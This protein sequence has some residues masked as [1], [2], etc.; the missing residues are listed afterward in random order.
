ML[1]VEE[2]LSL[3]RQRIEDACRRVNRDASE[4]T[5]VAVTKGVDLDRILRAINA[6]V[7]CIGENRIQEALLKYNGLQEMTRLGGVRLSWHMI[8]H[9]QTNKVKDAVEMFDVIHSVDSVRLAHAIDKEAGKIRKIQDV[10][11]EVNVSGEAA[12]YG[13][14]PEEVRGAIEEMVAL[15]HIRIRG[16]MTVAPIVDDSEQTR[17]F[18]RRLRQ[19]RDEIF[20]PSSVLRLPSF[21]SM[22]MTDDF[23][24]AVEEGA[25]HVRIGRGIFGER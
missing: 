24:T 19:L 11:C 2:N 7:T 4:V 3:C 18:F 8:G 16:L 25:T 13:F 10:L 21:L 17:P 23:E 12:K 6:G 14:T 5:L 1:Q 22:G 15:P 9:L 20:P